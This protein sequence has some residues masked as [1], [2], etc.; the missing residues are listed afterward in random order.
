MLEILQSNAPFLAIGAFWLIAGLVQT[1]IE[2]WWRK[3]KLNITKR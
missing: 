3:R 1:L 2:E